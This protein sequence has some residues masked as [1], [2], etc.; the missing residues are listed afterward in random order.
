MPEGGADR[1]YSSRLIL[2]FEHNFAAIRDSGPTL[3]AEAARLARLA[4]IEPNAADWVIPHQANGKMG[5]VMARHLGLRKE[6]IFVNADT[7]GNTGSAAI[8]I[9]LAQ[10]RQRMQGGQT[11]VVLGAEATKFMFG[12]FQYVHG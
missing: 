11:A 6:R 1:P 2:E 9:A 8:W 10:L 3:L 12:G 7:I 4:G 5:A